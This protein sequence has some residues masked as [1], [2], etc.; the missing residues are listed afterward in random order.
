MGV[1]RSTSNTLGP[2]L[3]LTNLTGG[4][5]NCVVYFTGGNT[6]TNASTG[7]SPTE[8][9][10]VLY[11]KTDNEYYIAGTITGL[12]SLTAGSP[13]F[14]GEAG[15]ITSSPPVPTSTRTILYLGFAINTTTLYFRPGIPII[16]G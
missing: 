3:V 13:Y 12:T 2:S 16:G 10:T 1:I 15:V 8:L 5:D 14:L 7:N 6:V 9:T 4:S 11:K